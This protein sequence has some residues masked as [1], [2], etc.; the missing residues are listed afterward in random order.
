MRILGRY[1]NS[2]RTLTRS[3]VGHWPGSDGTDRI[4]RCCS[5][6]IAIL[7]EYNV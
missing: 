5:Q 3:L 1:I 4:Q 6:N 2:S 7:V